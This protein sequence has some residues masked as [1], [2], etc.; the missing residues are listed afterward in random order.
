VDALAEVCQESQVLHPGAVQVKQDYRAGGAGQDG[1]VDARAQL[2]QA[3]GALPGERRQGAV[4]PQCP[5]A[6]VKDDAPLVLDEL[7][8]LPGVP[9]A[10]QVDALGNALRVAKRPV[11]LLVGI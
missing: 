3:L 6:M 10:L 5:F 7:V 9:V 8:V 1:P 4:G 11:R 2:C